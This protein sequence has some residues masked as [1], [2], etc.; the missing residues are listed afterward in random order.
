MRV[1]IKELVEKTFKEKFKPTSLYLFS[2]IGDTT[3][4]YLNLKYN[5]SGVE[6]NPI[7]REIFNKF[8]AELGSVLNIGISSMAIPFFYLYQRFVERV[9]EKIIKRKSPKPIKD[10]YDIFL[11]SLTSSSVYASVNNI[12]VYLKFP[13]PENNYQISFLVSL[14]PVAIYGYKYFKDLKKD[15]FS[16]SLNEK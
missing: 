6:A 8:G 9:Y 7:M 16:D 1:K 5:P 2:R 4:T 15:H 13:V 14:V 10:L 12:L 3:T 11:Y